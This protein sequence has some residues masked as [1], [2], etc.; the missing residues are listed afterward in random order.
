MNSTSAFTARLAVAV[1]RATVPN[2][3]PL[4]YSSLPFNL[5][6]LT[7]DLDINGVTDG[8]IW[9]HSTPEPGTSLGNAGVLLILKNPNDGLGTICWQTTTDGN[10]RS[11]LL[12]QASPPYA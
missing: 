12:G 3:I 11:P 1:Y 9:L 6:D 2:N 7:L 4:A 10:T 8:G 5:T